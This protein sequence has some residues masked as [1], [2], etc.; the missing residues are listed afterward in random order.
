[1]PPGS[2]ATTY[3]SGGVEFS[4]SASHD[5][6]TPLSMARATTFCGACAHCAGIT[7]STSVST[8]KVS[9]HGKVWPTITSAL[10]AVVGTN[11]TTRHAT[12][13]TGK[14]FVTK[15]SRPLFLENRLHLSTY[16]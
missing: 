16:K 4:V 14:A 13:E 6:T 15:R 3:E 7:T 12:S 5:T 9:E 2:T 11:A 10:A 8:A 1:M